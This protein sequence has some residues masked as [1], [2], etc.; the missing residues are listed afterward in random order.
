MERSLQIKV[1]S[2]KDSLFKITSCWYNR[3]P[4]SYTDKKKASVFLKLDITKAFDSVS[5]PFLIEVLKQLGFGQ[6]WRDIICGLLASSSTQVLL[7][8]YPER[9]IIHRR[10]LQQGN[11]LSS[12]LYI[13]VMDVLALLFNRAEDSGLLQQLSGR[14]KLHRISMY[15]DGVVI[16]LSPSA[17]DISIAMSILDLFGKA[18]RL[19]N[20]EQKSNVFPIRC[21]EDDLTA[22]PE[23]IAM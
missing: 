14:S 18:S 16:F 9:R 13:L 11:P 1:P 2:L 4:D 19:R 20:N 6:I 3:L 5:W 17:A 10:G 7:N 22:G 23:F 21:S 8:G 12:L 15:A